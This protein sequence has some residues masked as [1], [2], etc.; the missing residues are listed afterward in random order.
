MISDDELRRRAYEIMRRPYRKVIRGDDSEGYLGEVPALPGCLT[1]GETEEEALHN[2]HE[3]MLAWLTSALA[4][5]A[6]IPE[7]EH[8]GSAP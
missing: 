3:A 7:P 1:A 2:L 5:G 8:V 6:P 4:D